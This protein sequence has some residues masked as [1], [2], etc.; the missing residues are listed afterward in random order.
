MSTHHAIDAVLKSA[1]ERRD[2]PGVVAMA[3]DD[4]G[5]IYQG[6]FGKRDLGADAAMSTDTV[7]WIASMTKALV[8]AAAMQM[9]EQGKVG[10]DQDLGA[11]L[12]AL[13]DRRVIEGWDAE[14]KPRL[15]PARGPI[16]LRHLLT[17]TAGFSYEMWNADIGRYQAHAGLPGITSCENR[18]LETPLIADPGTRW[19]YGINIDFVGKLVEKLSGQRLDAYLQDHIFAPLGMS[20]TGF[21][22]RDDQRPRLAR[23]H[24]R[25][26]DGVLAP[27]DFETP[28]DP[29]FHMGGGGLYSTAGNYLTFCRMILGDGS[30]GGKQV[31]KPESVAAMRENQMGDL[32]VTRLVTVAEAASNDAEFFPGMVKKWSF[33]F[34]LN[35]EAVPARRAA[36]SLT[37]AGL[38]NTYFWIDPTSRVCG[39]IL[40]QILPFA[41]AKVLA[42]YDAFE[43]AVYAARGGER[44]VA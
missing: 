7:F 36:N 17:H 4:R 41:D 38:G 34:M 5:V 26:P 15:R 13:A 11:I 40:T 22:I 25:L 39:V 18:A 29:E 33:G 30:L 44:R 9:V 28:Q 12:P 37:W 6:A 32:V 16:T 8:S 31:L 2:V 42:L 43:E 35:T 3:A 1:A 19:E 23:M 10:I 20:E 24:A 27:I 14:G 21:K